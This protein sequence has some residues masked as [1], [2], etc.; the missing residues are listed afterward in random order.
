MSEEEI[1]NIFKVLKETKI[2]VRVNGEDKVFYG[3]IACGF[4]RYREGDQ[5]IYQ[6]TKRADT[7]MYEWKRMLK[8]MDGWDC[9]KG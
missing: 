9:P 7:K 2:E 4:D 5:D 8:E 6:I 3:R 1:G